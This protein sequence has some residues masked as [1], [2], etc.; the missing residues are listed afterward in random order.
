[1]PRTIR[2]GVSSCLVGENVR[3]DGGN[4]LNSFVSD[5]L[6]HRFELIS[7]CPESELGM[8][9][10]RETVDL[11]GNVNAPSMIGT[12]SRKDWTQL[13]NKWARQ[14]IE[15]LAELNLCG[16]V[17]KK[18]SPSCGV[19][20]VPVIQENREPLLEGKGL[21]AMAF[22]QAY[23]EIPVEDELNLED[24]TVQQDFLNRVTHYAQT[25]ES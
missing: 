8:G 22:M 10:P 21:F 11:E 19:R 9:V 23:P 5:T 17:F 18:G 6:G 16:F 20:K 4:R 14:R 13:M 2:I 12:H 1:M 3:Y 7:V 15:G 24:P 25:K